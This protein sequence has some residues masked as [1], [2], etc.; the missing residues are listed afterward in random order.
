GDILISLRKNLFG[1][2]DP[3][4]MMKIVFTTVAGYLMSEQPEIGIVMLIDGR[5]EWGIEEKLVTA[6]QAEFFEIMEKIIQQGQRMGVFNKGFNIEA[7]RQT[8]FGAG[9]GLVL[10][11]YL[12]TKT[13]YRANYS[14]EETVEMCEII[15]RAFFTVDKIF[16]NLKNDTNKKNDLIKLIARDEDLVNQIVKENKLVRNKG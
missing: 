2:N 15:Q 7:A 9:E 14:F 12:K 4:E 1:V 5:K 16:D 6:E 10:G 11:L 8:L 3:V 13:D